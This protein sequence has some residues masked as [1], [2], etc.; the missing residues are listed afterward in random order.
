MF[1]FFLIYVI[2]ILFS[3]N[4]LLQNSDDMKLTIVTNDFVDFFCFC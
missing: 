4:K 2:V 1:A 3:Y